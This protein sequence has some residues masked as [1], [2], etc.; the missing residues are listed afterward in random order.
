[1][2]LKCNYCQSH[3]TVIGGDPKPG[4]IIAYCPTCRR[5]I[6]VVPGLKKKR[7]WWQ[8][9]AH[10]RPRPSWITESHVPIEDGRAYTLDEV[11]TIMLERPF[12]LWAPA[13]RIKWHMEDAYSFD[14]HL[15]LRIGADSEATRLPH[16]ATDLSYTEMYGA[17][18]EL[19]PYKFYFRRDE[20]IIRRLQESD[21]PDF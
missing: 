17:W 1:M 8:L 4:D 14:G 5:G 18:Y 15:M 3:I 11:N 10:T 2:I 13:D 21:I 12:S 19:S 16:G 20:E 9:R 7:R 6:G